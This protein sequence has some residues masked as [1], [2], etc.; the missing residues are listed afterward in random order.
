LTFIDSLLNLQVQRSYEIQGLRALAV[1]LVL[2]FHAGWLPGGYIGVDVFYVISGYLITSLI[3]NDRNFTFRKFYARRAKRLLPMAFLV[4]LVTALLF[5]ELAPKASRLQFAKDLAASTWYVS[6]YLYAHWQNDYQNLGATPS[7]LIH[8]W[9]LAVEEQFYLFWPLLLMVFKSIRKQAVVVITILSFLLSLFL[10]NNA[11]IF[12]FYSLPTR[13]FELGLG[14][15]LAL[16]PVK[17]RL[18]WPGIALIF[19]GALLF[20]SQTPFPGVPAL[21]PIFGAAMVLT[22][23][24][25][26]F[27][28]SNAISQR[29]GDWSYSIYLWHWPLLTLPALY[30]QREL[31]D[32]E[33]LALLIICV[34]IS[35]LS[36]RYVENPIRLATVSNKRVLIATLVS[37]ALLT[38]TSVAIAAN[39]EELSYNLA[40]PSIY[41]NGCHQGYPGSQLKPGCVFGDSSAS[42]S[43]A[44]LGDS[45]AAQWFPAIDKWAKRAG[46]KLYTYTKSSCP[47][48]AIPMKDNGAFKAENCRKFRSA[49]LNE[50]AKIRPELVIL[51]NFEHYKVSLNAYLKAENFN[52]NYLLLRDTPWPNR[53]IPA[54]LTTK[55][56]CDTP[57]P[58]R[59]PFKSKNIFDPTPLLCSSKCPAI[60]DGLLAYRDQTHITISMAEHL[61]PALGAKLDS[62]VAG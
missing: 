5:W 42:R 22:S 46:F 61:E 52:F 60:V 51:G 19:S 45:H 17:S 21:L 54:C 20:N 57:L 1:T 41:A 23:L 28:L 48:F 9:S 15:I 59:I 43:V 39:N 27:L 2:L 35:A 33:K 12:A 32:K 8:Y 62:L 36:Y 14:A 47:A 53:D 7:P 3:I 18:T 38:T 31:G 29:I 10:L 24:K 49:A 50:I 26:N 37:G 55:A 44:L 16:Y 11:P 40:K 13:A 4:L 56:N 6:N 25:R 58:E 34:L 30:L